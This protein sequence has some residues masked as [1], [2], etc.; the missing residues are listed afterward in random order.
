MGWF[1]VSSDGLDLSPIWL[2]Y[3]G[4]ATS[5]PTILLSEP[6]GILADRNIDSIVVDHWRCDHIVL[7]SVAPQLPLCVLRI[8]VRFP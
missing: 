6:F 5:L 8:T 1:V 2:G 7:R 3:V 4:L